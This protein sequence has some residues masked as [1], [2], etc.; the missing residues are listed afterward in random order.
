[1]LATLDDQQP[2]KFDNTFLQGS[3]LYSTQF[4]H[5]ASVFSYLSTHHR[6]TVTRGSLQQQLENNIIPVYFQQTILIKKI[7]EGKNYMNMYQN[8][9]GTSLHQALDTML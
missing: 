3:G 8:T 9:L 5:V 6:K 2:I 1:M 4:S 7:L